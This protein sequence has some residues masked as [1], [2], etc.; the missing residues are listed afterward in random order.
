MM[1]EIMKLFDDDYVENEISSMR[2]AALIG[3]GFVSNMKLNGK[4]LL[5]PLKFPS[6]LTK[7]ETS[8]W[9]L[10]EIDMTPRIREECNTYKHQALLV[11]SRIKAR[12]REELLAK[13]QQIVDNSSTTTVGFQRA[14][15]VP[16][17]HDYTDSVDVNQSF[18]FDS[19]DIPKPSTSRMS[20]G[21]TGGAIS[22][23]EIEPM[24][25][26]IFSSSDSS[27]YQQT[28]IARDESSH[29][30]QVAKILREE[31]TQISPTDDVFE[32]ELSA[33]SSTPSSAPL[34][35]KSTVEET[36][37]KPASLLGNVS[38]S[39]VSDK[40]SRDRI[41]S[42]SDVAENSLIQDQLAVSSREDHN[43]F[44]SGDSATLLSTNSTD[45]MQYMNG[46]VSTISSTGTL[47]TR[48]SILR[49]SDTIVGSSDHEN[50]HDV[51]VIQRVEATSEASNDPP[52][53]SQSQPHS[54]LEV[55]QRS[56]KQEHLK[57][58]LQHLS[59]QP[60]HIPLSINNR[61]GSSESSDSSTYVT[62]PETIRTHMNP[63]SFSMNYDHHSSELTDEEYLQLQTQHFDEM[64]KRLEE[65]QREQ[66]AQLL[67][68]QQHEQ[69]LLQLEMREQERRLKK[70][71]EE[72]RQQSAVTQPL[73]STTDRGTDATPESQI[74]D[75]KTKPET[76]FIPNQEHVAPH[77]HH[78]QP[79]NRREQTPTIIVPEK[80]FTAEMQVNFNRLSAV[81]KGF[82]TRRLLASEKVQAL[83]KTVK[84]T[85]Q[86]A[87][88]FQ[89]ETPIKRGIY[90]SQ[91]VTL[92]ERVIAQLRAALLEIHDIFFTI[93]ISQRMSYIALTR[94][95]EQER[96]FREMDSR[97]SSTGGQS[98]TRKVSSATLKAIERKK[99]AKAAEEAMI[100]NIRPKTAPITSPTPATTRE[101]TNRSNDI[102]LRALKPIQGHQPQT[103]RSNIG[104]SSKP[105][106]DDFNKSVA[107]E[108]PKTAPGKSA[109]SVHQI[110]THYKSKKTDNT[111][112]RKNPSVSNANMKK[113]KAVSNSV[114]VS[115]TGKPSRTKFSS[116]R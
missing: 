51:T 64:R 62:A 108:R 3:K 6:V 4:P 100:A 82:L 74:I 111:G 85:A 17:I 76:A 57:R 52:V 113:H 9:G 115:S 56:G 109:S 18:D 55:Q 68:E 88:T 34:T 46:S 92:Q 72:L 13:V 5:P 114:T 86:F 23:G 37:K 44:I 110:P 53:D 16:P 40:S 77:Y 60:Q 101:I 66:L 71:E 106:K 95:L 22:P 20:S 102:D 103:Q 24:A 1:D 97:R 63:S 84:D 28:V 93:P 81:A 42:G 96:R 79:N 83:V 105:V 26:Y 69:Y 45:I 61:G 29:F 10:F 39:P 31:K 12:K 67:W 87:I 54:E 75:H 99:R 33:S 107:N 49:D 30:K 73:S 47:P 32:E 25:S 80:A 27:E 8:I 91:D 14:F 15:T 112:M 38:L 104:T 50:D 11:E 43:M 89:S 21:G 7:T 59:Q 58:Y 65:Q 98:L 2:I 41:S 48:E 90:S 78:F 35:T 36:T 19:G 70:A 116:Q 94:E